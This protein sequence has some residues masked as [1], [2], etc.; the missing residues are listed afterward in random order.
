VQTLDPR[1]GHRGTY[2]ARVGPVI[3]VTSDAVV[4]SGPCFDFSPCE[5]VAYPRGP[6]VVR[7]LVMEAFGAVAIESPRGPVVVYERQVVDG[8]QLR[9]R[10]LGGLVDRPL[11]TYPPDG[12]SLTEPDGRLFSG[13]ELPS[14]TLALVTDAGFGADDEHDVPLLFRLDDRLR[15]VPVVARDRS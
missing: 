15:L 12:R 14:D 6:G 5:I 11:M 1:T 7:R 8:L 13:A 10:L 3:G 9:V 4:A 2:R